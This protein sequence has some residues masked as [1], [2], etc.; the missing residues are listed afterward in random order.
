MNTVDPPRSLPER[1]ASRRDRNLRP[2]LSR[3]DVDLTASS[4]P[5]EGRR[6][7]STLD[8]TIRAVTAGDRLPLV[9][10]YRHPPTT[11]QVLR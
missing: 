9:F 10:R 2:V 3:K 1:P 5:E 6:P 7:F 11:Q 4:E 8:V